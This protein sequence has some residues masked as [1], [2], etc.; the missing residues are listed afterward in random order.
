MQEAH[1]NFVED[2]NMGH[3]GGINITNVHTSQELAVG[4]YLST[5]FVIVSNV[6]KMSG[7]VR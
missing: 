1:I 4:G 5:G 2:N 3:C 6:V 7:P